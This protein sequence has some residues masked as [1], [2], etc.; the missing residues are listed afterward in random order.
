MRKYLLRIITFS[1]LLALIFS[2][3]VPLA[4]GAGQRDLKARFKI[5]DQICLINGQ[6]V[7]MSHPPF[8]KNGRTFVPIRVLAKALDLEDKNVIWDP[9]SRSVTLVK[10]YQTVSL[11]NAGTLKTVVVKLTIVAGS[12][13]MHYSAQD[14]SNSVNNS[15]NNSIELDALPEII[16]SQMFVP[17][18]FVAEA[19]G[20][21]VNWNAEERTVEI[22]DVKIS[23]D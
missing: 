19:F 3:S 2:F 15:A 20:Y 23:G 18:R 22:W 21:E 6:S 14:L 8:I 4:M 10:E 17:L 1:T 12:S 16:N 5:D 7:A 11:E 9:S 13:T